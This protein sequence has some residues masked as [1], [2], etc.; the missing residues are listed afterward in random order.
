MLTTCLWQ[1]RG[2]EKENVARIKQR[3]NSEG[4]IQPRGKMKSCCSA[5]QHGII[6]CFKHSKRVL[7]HTVMCC[8][9]LSRD[10]VDSRDP[11]PPEQLRHAERYRRCSSRLIYR[12][13]VIRLWSDTLETVLCVKIESPRIAKQRGSNSPKYGFLP[14]LKV[15][16]WSRKHLSYRFHIFMPH[17][18]VRLGFPEQRLTTSKHNL[19]VVCFILQPHFPLTERATPSTTKPLSI[20]LCTVVRI[21]L[22]WL[23]SWIC[24]FI[25][26]RYRFI[27]SHHLVLREITVFP[28]LRCI[29]L[30]YDH[31]CCYK[32]I[33]VQVLVMHKG[34]SVICKI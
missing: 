23:S 3:N 2:W 32:P 27:V 26:L 17:K 14:P 19:I 9:L 5:A 11:R 18:S 6:P 25:K 22:I 13:E 15:S 1:N 29:N 20:T 33:K 31:L 28:F 34:L 10:S 24:G 7:I 12:L 21:P 4:K 16:L 30:M 8:F